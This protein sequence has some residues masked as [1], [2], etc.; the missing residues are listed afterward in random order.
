M[1]SGQ[2]DPSSFCTNASNTR[3]FIRTCAS[4]LPADD[5][6][7]ESWEY[8]R[9]H[10]IRLAHTQC[11]THMLWAAQNLCLCS[12]LLVL[13]KKQKNNGQSHCKKVSKHPLHFLLSHRERRASERDSGLNRYDCSWEHG[14]VNFTFYCC[15]ALGDQRLWGQ[16]LIWV[17]E[18]QFISW[19]C[20]QNIIEIRC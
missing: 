5:S 12:S 13:Q 17:L 1:N 10:F 18:M 14:G 7:N 20:H 15:F 11:N 3:Y 4:F 2:N 9:L 16:K 8:L 6:R 19:P